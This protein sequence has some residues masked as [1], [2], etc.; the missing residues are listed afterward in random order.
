MMKMKVKM[1]KKKIE[2]SSPYSLEQINGMVDEVVKSEGIMKKN[3]KGMFL[4]NDDSK[5]FC[6]FMCIVLYLKDQE[7]FLP[8]VKKWILYVDGEVDDLGTHYKKMKNV[9]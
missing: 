1:D 8:F 6:N 3:D 9:E 7:W 5:D 2:E 4:G